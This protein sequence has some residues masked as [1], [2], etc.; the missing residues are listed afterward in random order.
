[1]TVNRQRPPTADIPSKPVAA[2]LAEYERATIAARDA[3]REFEQLVRQ[4]DKARRDDRIATTAALSAGEPVPPPVH[5]RDHE[6]AV[7]V[8]ERVRAAR[9]EIADAAWSKFEALWDAHGA[10]MLSAVEKAD[11]GDRKEYEKAVDQLEA[12][13]TRR[14]ARASLRAQL[15]GEGG[16][17]DW[18]V[19]RADL[20]PVV[21]G[22]GRGFIPLATIVESLR[23]LGLPQPEPVT[24]PDQVR[25]RPLAE[26]GVSARIVPPGGP[27][28]L[29][30]PG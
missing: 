20:L 5:Q 3:A 28:A 8:A 30:V 9:R 10:E 22:P 7:E 11:E 1:M 6:S 14:A 15:G 27:G 18:L 29:R 24:N 19:V 26:Q 25:H 21:D 2:A 17:G 12:I 16:P 13:T 4:G 23:Q